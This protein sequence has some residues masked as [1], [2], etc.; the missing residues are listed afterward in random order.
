MAKSKAAGVQV[1]LSMP[2]NGVYVAQLVGGPANIPPVQLREADLPAAFASAG[3]SQ[4]QLVG[5]IQWLQQGITFD[6]IFI[7]PRAAAALFPGL[8]VEAAAARRASP[9]EKPAKKPRAKKAKVKLPPEVVMDMGR[10]SPAV[11][12]MAE[13]GVDLSVLRQ[14]GSYPSLHEKLALELATEIERAKDPDYAAVSWA[15]QVEAQDY[16]NAHGF[17]ATLTYMLDMREANDAPKEHTYGA[18]LRPPGYASVPDGFVSFGPHPDF[19]HGTVTY[20]RRLT[21]EEQRHF[22]L[23]KIPNDADVAALV[24]ALIER[25]GEHAGAW[26]ELLATHP[27]EARSMVGGD[28]DKHMLHV[29][30]DAVVQRVA[31]ELRLR[32][33]RPAGDEDEEDR[34]ISPSPVSLPPQQ[35]VVQPT[36]EAVDFIPTHVSNFDSEDIIMA[37]PADGNGAVTYV[38]LRGEMQ[39]VPWATFEETYDTYSIPDVKD[40]VEHI[41]DDADAIFTWRGDYS[42]GDLVAFYT[43]ARSIFDLFEHNVRYSALRQL[44]DWAAVHAELKPLLRE[45]VVTR[46][47]ESKASDS[48]VLVRGPDPRQLALGYPGHMVPSAEEIKREWEG[49][50]FTEGVRNPNAIGTEVLACIMGGDYFGGAKSERVWRDVFKWLDSEG[51]LDGGSVFGLVAMKDDFDNVRKLHAKMPPYLRDWIVVEGEA[52]PADIY[53][54]HEGAMFVKNLYLDL[55]DADDRADRNGHIVLDAEEWATLLLGE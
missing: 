53:E 20:P 43:G 14:P 3:W 17:E 19:R 4:E 35:H 48:L 11:R 33:V 55:G 49:F 50:V 7:D 31:E 28:F 38:N 24:E 40:L 16:F 44:A 21:L 2:A 10:A 18:A 6:S 9:A 39:T 8:V 1:G 27:R 12:E 52:T 30:V 15:S 37:G 29:P 36:T 34:S 13:E 26:L 32:G 42:L 54:Q 51:W 5:V 22:D 25:L 23:V 41:N 47:E 46:L 45:H